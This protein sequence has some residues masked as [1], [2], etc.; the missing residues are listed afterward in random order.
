MTN[1]ND[2]NH[3]IENRNIIDLCC[4]C[5][6][7]GLCFFLMYL[8][9]SNIYNSDWD[10]YYDYMFWNIVAFGVLTGLAGFGFIAIIFKLKQL[11]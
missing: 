1:E 3:T 5:F 6:G 4:Y 2:F 9:G 8:V 11:V 10:I 7:M